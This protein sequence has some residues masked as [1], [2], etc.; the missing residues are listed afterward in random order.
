MSAHSIA[1]PNFSQPGMLVSSTGYDLILHLGPWSV[2]RGKK[3]ASFSGLLAA[4]I[5]EFGGARITVPGGLLH[6]LELSAVLERGGDEC[7]MHRVRRLAAIE[8]EF[9]SIFPDHVI[10]GVLSHTPAFLPLFC[11][12]LDHHPTLRLFNTLVC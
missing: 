2:V 9:V 1:Q 5:V 8:T 4:P 6:V 10:E 12:L 11:R 3:L 7:R